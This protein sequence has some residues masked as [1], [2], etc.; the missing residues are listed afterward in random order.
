MIDSMQNLPDGFVTGVII[1]VLAS[2]FGFV[3]TM[4]WDI[5]KNHRDKMLK[6]KAVSIALHHEITNNIN[7]ESKG[8]WNQRGQV[9]HFAYL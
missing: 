3:L 4:L 9:F 2:A 6:D 1:G 5:Y 7:M 8:S